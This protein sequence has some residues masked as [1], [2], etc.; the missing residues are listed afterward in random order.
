[1]ESSNKV[2]IV[3]ECGV[4][5]GGDISLAHKYI[6]EAFA[7]GA[8][9]IK[10]Q[11][12]LPGEITGTYTSKCDYMLS[13]KGEKLSR[14]EISELLRLKYEEF[15]QLK[16]HA[17]NVGIEFMSTPDGLQSLNFLIENKLLRTLKIGSTEITNIPLLKEVA[18]INLPI[19]LSTGTAQFDEVSTAINIF[20]ER[21]NELIL[22][23]CTSSYPC[24]DEFLNLRVLSQY[25]DAFGISVG[26][27]DHSIGKIA[28]YV[29]IGLGAKVIEKHIYIDSEIWTPDKNASMHI[30][31]FRDFVREIRRI[32]K[33]L[34][35]QYKYRT[36]VEEKN[37]SGIRRG[38]C[39]SRKLKAGTILRKE[40]IC[41]KRPFNGL[42]H[43]FINIFINKSLICDKDTD[44]PFEISD[45]CKKY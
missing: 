6:D 42:D 7:S 22:M 15:I 38:I 20:R 11:T 14:Y 8:D 4:N 31:E 17:D 16:N 32:E 35:T 25:K 41:L 5:H 27:S 39:A 10:F 36:Q 9:A 24:D 21:L 40:D 44:Q 34:G 1:M 33:M 37:L 3:A 45:I 2:K 23:Q 43:S 19:Y 12:W 18:K 30:K 13:E 29:A 26:F 28:S